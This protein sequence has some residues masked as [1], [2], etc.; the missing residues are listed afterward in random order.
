MILT[1]SDIPAI[2][3]EFSHY[4]YLCRL[5]PCQEPAILDRG[6]VTCVALDSLAI[7]CYFVAEKTLD[8]FKFHRITKPNEIVMTE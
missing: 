1:E 2:K 5:T 6:T 3:R 8:G 4:C 7:D